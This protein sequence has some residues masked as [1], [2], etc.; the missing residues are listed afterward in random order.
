MKGPIAKPLWNKGLS[1]RFRL[2]F[3][4]AVLILVILAM[5]TYNYA[6]LHDIK[7]Y[8][9]KQTDEAAKELLGYQLKQEVEGLS[10][11]MSGFMLSRNLDMRPEFDKK[12]A[13]L[14]TKAELLSGNATT[15]E[16]RKWKASFDTTFTEYAGVF[17]QAEELMK[18]SKLTAAQMNAGLSRLY[19]ASQLHKEFVFETIDKFVKKYTADAQAA[20]SES[21][22]L[23]DRTAAVSIVVP[24][25][26]LLI[27][28]VVAFLLVRSFTRPIRELQAAMLRIAQGDLRLR[29]GSS[30]KDELGTLS[31]S[32]DQMIGQVH[33]MLTHTRSIASS[34]SGHAG[35]F[36]RFSRETAA[37]N[38]NIIQAIEEISH[39]ADQQAQQS[40]TSST[41]IGELEL[42]VGGI[43]EYARDMRNTSSEAERNTRSGARS[44]E[45]LRSAAA[46]TEDRVE[47]A[48]TAMRAVADSSSQIGKIVQTIT[49]ISTQTNILSLNA[50]IEAARAG[51]SGRGFSVIAEEVR[52]LSQQTGESSKHV[53]DIICG[54]TGH[55]AELEAEL[56]KAHATLQL[57]NAKVDSTLSAFN[58]IQDSMVQVTARIEGIHE[59]VGQVQKRTSML[60]ESVQHVAAVAEETAAGVEEVN[61]TS[62]EQDASIRQI[63]VQAEDI[64]RL[65]GEL[66]REISR[67]CIEEEAGSDEAAPASP[68]DGGCPES[69]GGE[70][71][72]QTLETAA[73]EASDEPPA[74]AGAADRG[75][76]PTEEAQ[77]RSERDDRDRSQAKE[78][79]LVGV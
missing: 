69:G 63:A 61:S 20:R 29:I 1:L 26:V 31:R 55:I 5:G 77:V 14:K 47:Q 72:R 10:L 52:I 15:A 65:S 36:T 41:L 24:A 16:E 56:A 45:E 48:L 22:S 64:S 78:K 35:Q 39:G 74:G 3:S 34:L 9:S 8:S 54:L 76:A 19:E 28:V 60:I 4:F 7:D 42:E 62:V 37:A 27:T 70:N 21:E 59:R 67:F 2:V 25:V 46:D 30:R 44:V 71:G 66:F 40:E 73:A 17:G 53:S 32:F 75:L 51:A 68:P 38:S 12:L 43:Y 6:T 18:D 50:A 58:S 13:E 79:E 33:D 11:Y 23:M 57:Q 49:D